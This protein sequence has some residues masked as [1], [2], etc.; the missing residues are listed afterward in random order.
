MGWH[1]VSEPS[2]SELSLFPRPGVCGPRPPTFVLT[3][4]SLK[5][6]RFYSVS[7]FHFDVFSLGLVWRVWGLPPLISAPLALILAALGLMFGPLGLL[8]AGSCALVGV[9]WGALGGS[10]RLLAR[11][12]PVCSPSW[13]PL[14][15]SWAIV[16]YFGRSWPALSTRPYSYIPLLGRRLLF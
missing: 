14:R 5:F 7:S 15:V 11:I 4:S 10:W 1:S 12:R 16:S 13:A 3:A 2:R 8:V 6:Q 9:S